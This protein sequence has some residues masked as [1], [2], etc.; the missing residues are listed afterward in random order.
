MKNFKPLPQKDFFVISH[1]HKDRVFV[2]IWPKKPLKFWNLTRAKS[3]QFFPLIL[4]YFMQNFDFFRK[5]DQFWAIFYMSKMFF[6]SN[7]YQKPV[8]MFMTSSHPCERLS[9]IPNS[10]IHKVEKWKM[11][12][13][14]RKK[15]VFVISHEHKDR[16]FEVIRPKKTYRHIKYWSRIDLFFSKNQNFDPKHK[17]PKNQW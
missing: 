6:W 9:K 17:I 14:F 8:F 15:N 11:L 2:V 5:M 3:V 1:E 13:H 16:F 10:Q 12:S 4:W 7:H